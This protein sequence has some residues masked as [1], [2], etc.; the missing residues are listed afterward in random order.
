MP[1]HYTIEKNLLC[2]A[3][4]ATQLHIFLQRYT[5]YHHLA[6]NYTFF[7]ELGMLIIQHSYLGK[8]GGTENFKM[9]E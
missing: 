6:A 5:Q 3:F 7:R 4:V 8:F 2:H 9:K 1:P